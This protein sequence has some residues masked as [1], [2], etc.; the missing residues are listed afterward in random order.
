MSTNRSPGQPLL[1]AIA[2]V[3]M[4][5]GDPVPAQEADEP[6]AAA[7][8]PKPACST[9]RSPYRDFDFWVGDW[10]VFAPG[11]D[12]KLGENSI[13]LRESGCLIVERWTDARGGTGM[14]MNFH[15]PL[16]GAWRQVWQSPWGFID[17]SGGLDDAG[18]MVL[19]G[20]IHYNAR[21]TSRDF[22]G[23]WTPN[24]DGTVLQEFW[25]RSDETGEWEAWFV[26]EY[27]PRP[28]SGSAAQPAGER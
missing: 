18:R 27:R 26:G 13:E 17:Y 25:Q 14:S 21:G 2:L 1:V 16:E 3:G 7:P 9:D 6:A 24:D 12:R 8:P 5:F 20:T 23:R 4:L 19:E 10:D 11:T 22:R 15:D 28:V